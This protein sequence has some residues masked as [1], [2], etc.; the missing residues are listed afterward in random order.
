MLP[1]RAKHGQMLDMVNLCLIFGVL[2]RKCSDINSYGTILYL[3]SVIK[4]K[5]DAMVNFM[6]VF[7]P[8]PIVHKY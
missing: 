4:C 6:V 8:G 7:D 1:R 2:V 5:F 3:D